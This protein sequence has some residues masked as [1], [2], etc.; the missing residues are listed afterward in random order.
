ME[1]LISIE[2]SGLKV[3]LPDGYQLVGKIDF[4]PNKIHVLSGPN[5]VGKTSCFDMLEDLL[6]QKN[7][8]FSR[9]FQNDLTSI[10]A[11]LKVKDLFRDLSSLYPLDKRIEL[12]KTSLK[13]EQLL[14]LC[15]STLSG[16]EAQ[17]LKIY[18]AL[19]PSRKMYLLDEPFNHLEQK[20]S[21]NLGHL[22]ATL[23]QEY[24]QTFLISDHQ[25]KVAQDVEYKIYRQDKK[26]HILLAESSHGVI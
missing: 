14:N 24:G 26:V 13:I 1:T 7:I 16:G 17:R 23:S 3:Q 25:R 12:I 8:S 20:F 9:C 6:S 10:D 5:G 19:L 15:V 2:F 21:L 11:S 4:L 18:L 22:L